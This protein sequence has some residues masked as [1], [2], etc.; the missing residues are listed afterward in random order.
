MP[1]GRIGPY[2]ITAPLGAGG[3]GEVYR[4]TDTKLGREVAI[5]VLPA[6]V[7]GDHERLARF[8]RE[9][10]LLASLNHP[11]IAHVYG[12][13]SAALEDGSTGH[14][15]AME[16]V[17]GEDLAARLKRGAVPVEEA[18]EIARQIAEALEEAHEKGIVHRDLKPA[19][20]KVTPEGKVKVLD[21]GLAKAYAGE[22]ASGSAPDL[23]RS[24][25]LAHTGTQAGVILGTAAYMSPEQA[26]GKAVDKRS[27]IWSFGVVLYEMLTG[28]QLFSGETVSD[29]L[30]A[31]LTREPEWTAL[32]SG[33]G[34]IQGILERC[35][36]RDPRRRIRDAGDVGF[37]LARA[38]QRAAP[39]RVSE[40]GAKGASRLGWLGVALMAA[41]AGAVV[42][43]VAGPGAPVP[44]A[45]RHLSIQLAPEQRLAFTDNGTLTFSPDG[46]SLVFPGSED[47]RRAL[48]RRSLESPEVTAIQGT[49]GGSAPTFSMDGRALAFIA[50]GQF[51]K[52]APEGGRPLN[53]AAQQGAGGGAWLP[54]GGFVFAP[55]YSD[56]LFRVSDGGA[57]TRLTTPD[58]AG[59]ELGHWWPCVLP[60]SDFVLFTGFRTPADTSR[61]RAVSLSTGEVKD[62]AEGGLF[63][64]YVPGYLLYARGGRLYA[65]PFDPVRAAV[66]G[67]ARAVVE[68][69]FTSQ[70]GGYALFDVSSDGTLAYVPASAADAPRDL[71]WVDRDG[72]AQPV[73]SEPRRFVDV[74]LSP[75]DRIAA[76]AIQGDSLDLWALDIQ[77]GTL[78]RVTSTPGTEFGAEWAPDGSTL[79]FVVDR[80]P[81]EIHR[82]AFGSA[83][84]SEP[85]WKERAE[86]DTVV[87]AISP[88]GRMVAYRLSE[89]D[90]GSNVWVRSVDGTEPPRPFRATP[91]AEQFPTFSP[92]GRWLAYE[93]DETGRPE[94][95][96]EAFPGPGERRQVS[97]DGGSEPLW[98][99][100]GEL[101]YRHDA[102]LRAVPTRRGAR[103]ELGAAQTVYSM[104]PYRGNETDR[105]YDVTADGRRVITIRSPEATAPRRIEVVTDWLSQLP[106]LIRGEQ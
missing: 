31:V 3:M 96:V 51:R 103:F 37:E 29:V 36:E 72:R 25:T 85:L 55:M 33:A 23:S 90:T 45:S 82:I 67:P 104:A 59:G 24:P 81:F 86:L 68:D 56:G 19:N 47:G 106:R 6:E 76:L 89:P 80:P 93:S 105:T 26:R 40:T 83:A 1:F 8:E 87:S 84:Q 88:D 75:D 52:V 12:F 32:P 97:S 28:R 50:G 71:V 99:A 7:A 94:I 15:L 27:D 46:R 62:V 65:A 53:I 17:E 70:T 13:E 73:T 35:L 39:T 20:V 43:R 79:F 5:K 49:E 63:G 11:N 66:S 101:F 77:R 34:R 60:G 16:L 38:A 74:S 44:R 21:F 48:F 102:E 18:L 10:K 92:D 4:A 95:Y 98:A 9:A 100:S 22:A 57:P 69:V 14:F 61:V 54:G 78:S 41:L 2:E 91:A 64:R 42:A 58:R 30:A